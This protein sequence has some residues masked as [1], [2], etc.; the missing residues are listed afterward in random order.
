MRI[1]YPILL[2]ISIICCD[3]ACHQHHP[4]HGEYRPLSKGLDP[5]SPRGIALFGVPGQSTQVPTSQKKNYQI[6]PRGGVY[7]T[8][9]SQKKVYIKKSASEKNTPNPPN[10]GKLPPQRN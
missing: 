5:Y 4:I 2:V 8:T 7:Y 9:P 10:T 3:T 6:G 1:I